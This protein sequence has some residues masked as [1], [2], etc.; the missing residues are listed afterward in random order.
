MEY[1]TESTK[2]TTE[3]GK[4]IGTHLKGGEVLL[5]E[6]DLGAGKTTFV[7]G[8]AKGLQI[9]TKISSPTFTI[10]KI[11]ESNGGIGLLHID[12]YRLYE[13][14]PKATI[15]EL[16]IRDYL[17]NRHVVVVEW[18]DK[19]AS[20]FGKIE[21]LYNFSFQVLDDDKRMIKTNFEM[22]K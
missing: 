15:A 2:E 1:I 10:L 21:D 22:Q 3:L 11:Y 9:K 5:L 12:L 6:G 16:G 20:E 17:D 19:A 8:L 4:K 13:A 14:D 7:Q 18:G